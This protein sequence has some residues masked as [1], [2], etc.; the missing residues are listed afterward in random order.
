MAGCITFPHAIRYPP[1]FLTLFGR[2]K[3]TSWFGFAERA[4]SGSRLPCAFFDNRSRILVITQSGKL[5][6]A[7]VVASGPFQE[8]NLRYEFGIDPNTLLHLLSRQ[9]FAPSRLSRFWQ[10][11]EGTFNSR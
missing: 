9:G 3:Y 8:F 1:A 7:Q 2:G 11:D 4:P 10:V 5:C 6:M